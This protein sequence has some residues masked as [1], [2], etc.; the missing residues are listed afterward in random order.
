VLGSSAAFAPFPYRR[1][2]PGTSVATNVARYFLKPRCRFVVLRKGLIPRA[3]LLVRFLKPVGKLG[4]IL[5]PKL[6]I[7]FL[8]FAI[9]NVSLRSNPSLENLLLDPGRIDAKMH[10]MRKRIGTIDLMRY[11]PTIVLSDMVGALKSKSSAGV[12]DKFGTLFCG[13][14]ERTFWSSWLLSL[15]CRRSYAGNPKGIYRKPRP[16]PYRQREGL[17]GLNSVQ[18]RR[19]CWLYSSNR[20]KYE[21]SPR[22]CPRSPEQYTRYPPQSLPPPRFRRT[23]WY[24]RCRQHAPM[25]FGPLRYL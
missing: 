17:R 9:I 23:R 2:E 24:F 8:D 25:S 5:E 11:L 1:F 18:A 20:D 6:I 14:H 19:P 12:L 10:A 22:G 4:V 21:P 13:K 3:I 15:F 16:L 7:E